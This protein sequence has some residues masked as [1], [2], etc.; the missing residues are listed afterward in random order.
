MLHVLEHNEQ[1]DIQAVLN[2]PR[3]DEAILSVCD[4]LIVSLEE[5]LKQ[6]ASMEALLIKMKSKYTN[7]PL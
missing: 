2:T 6:V 5:A 3:E 1:A 4:Q 7:P